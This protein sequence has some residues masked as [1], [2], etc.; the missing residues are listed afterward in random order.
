MK[1]DSKTNTKDKQQK[2]TISSKHESN[3]TKNIDHSRKRTNTRLPSKASPA[4]KYS[5]SAI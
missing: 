5:K 2:V 1:K 4:L 3:H